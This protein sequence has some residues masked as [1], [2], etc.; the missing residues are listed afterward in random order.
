[1]RRSNPSFNSSVTR[2]PSR[3]PL[4]SVLPRSVKDIVD[5]RRREGF[6][7]ER[8]HVAPAQDPPHPDPLL[9]TPPPPSPGEEGEQQGPP[10]R[11]SLSRGGGWG[12]RERG[13]VRV[14]GG[15]AILF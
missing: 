2:D 8:G 10:S 13:R 5:S 4:G 7:V 3:V 1:M 12:G 11:V 15:G 6:C 9:P 14:L